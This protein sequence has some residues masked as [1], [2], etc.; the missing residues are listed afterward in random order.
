[1]AGSL[2]FGRQ[3]C[4]PKGEASAEYRFPQT[5]K[6]CVGRRGGSE[7]LCGPVRYAVVGAAPP[8]P[9]VSF[10]S[11]RATLIGSMPN[12]FDHRALVAGYN[13][14]WSAFGRLA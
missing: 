9:C 10:E 5:V 11:F 13:C 3:Y 12:C 14:V 4:I 2:G 6:P 1:M 7:G 8:F